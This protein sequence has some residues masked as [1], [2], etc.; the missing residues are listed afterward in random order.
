[1]AAN[2]RAN[3]HFE[4]RHELAGNDTAARALQSFDRSV[5]QLRALLVGGIVCIVEAELMGVDDEID[6]FRKP[7][8]NA[9]CFRQ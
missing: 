7:L 1:V 9:K 4:S 2:D 5:A 3:P 6:V 8:D